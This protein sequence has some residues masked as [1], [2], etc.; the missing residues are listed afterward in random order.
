M[1]KLIQ[2]KILE[3]WYS[4]D[5]MLFGTDACNV[6]AEGHVY[7][8][9]ISL[10]AACLSSLYEYYKHISYVPKFDNGVPVSTNKLIECSEE[11]IKYARALASRLISKTAVRESLE[12]KAVKLSEKKRFSDATSFSKQIVD[13]A[14]LRLT[15]DNILVGI[16]LTECGDVSKREDFS[17]SIFHESYKMYRDSL[18]KLAKTC[19]KKEVTEGVK[20]HIDKIKSKIS[21]TAKKASKA[22]GKTAKKVSIATTKGAKKAWKVGNTPVSQLFKGKKKVKKK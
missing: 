16:P 20:D 10:K 22:T 14:F 11:T 2:T 13:E 3:H 1:A 17:G 18:V 12:K 7:E 6:I 19:A 5:E 8:Q 4:I 9:Y 15:M 21:K